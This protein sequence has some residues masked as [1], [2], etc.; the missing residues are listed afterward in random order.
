[1]TDAQVQNVPQINQQ[2]GQAQHAQQVNQ[3][4]GQAQ[5]AQHVYVYS[6]TN[7]A[8]PEFNWDG[9]LP[10]EF[11][12]FKRYCELLL[13][14]P[15]YTSRSGKEIVS[16]MLLWMGKKAVVIFD[17]MK[18]LTELQK[19]Q[20]EEVWK[21]FSAYFEPKTNFRLARFQLRD[22]KQEQT[23]PVDS[24]LTRLRT[25]AGKCHFSDEAAID[26]NILDQLIKG[27]AHTQVR[28][29]LLEQPTTLTLNRA[30]DFARTFEATQHHLQHFQQEV[31]VHESRKTQHKQQKHQHRQRSRSKSQNRKQKTK[32]S[33]YSCGTS[34]ARAKEKCPAKDQKCHKCGRIGHWAKYCLNPNNPVN[35]QNKRINAVEAD[36]DDDDITT[37][38]QNLTF[39]T[40]SVDSHT[41][42]DTRTEAFAVIKI[43]P[44]DGFVANLK[45]KV[46]TGAEVN[47]LPLRTFAQIYPDKISNGRPTNTKRST[48]ILTAYN[49][50]T[51]EQFGTITIP[52]KFQ[53]KWSNEEFYIAE[54]NGPV[55]FG[56][57]TS[58][59][60]Q[61]VKMQCQITTSKITQPRQQQ[62]QPKPINSLA[63]L[64]DSY[65]D[66]FEGL[67]RFP[68]KYHLD[69]KE[70]ATPSVHPPRKTPIQ[71]REKIEAELQ[72]MVDLDVIRQTNE[73]TD[74]VSSI[75]YVQK[76]DGSLRICLDPRD[77]NT[78]LKRGQH[79]A[80]TLEEL[81]HK[82]T[83]A[84]T[85]SKLDAKSGYW[86][87]QLDEE[88]QLLTTFNSPLG[89]YC[90]KRLPF[91]LRT[92]QDVF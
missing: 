55:I 30:L 19:Q 34:H 21:A 84:T 72:R 7:I 3:Q 76:P 39:Q 38:F 90:F 75:T 28:K 61:L 87:I 4:Q 73:P 63:D 18:E 78:A 64:R 82:L 5:H 70:N 62:T 17:N 50:N 60:L 56:L 88:S 83:G 49:G 14:T 29:K 66:R 89:R 35:K 11:K 92:S 9:E 25:Q 36:E 46:D 37:P 22:M 53:G 65:P 1:M 80:P 6:D 42:S 52:C 91:G 31:S 41:M 57:P 86:A 47:I 69:L 32:S 48:A 33:C 68:K 54:V 13:T 16:L 40:I 27:T 79:R 26:D 24:F 74:W 2:Q 71:L 51:I 15:S 10:Q 44:Y 58:N 45:G 67:G 81:S 12:T 77:I 20:P 59:T 85:F 43:K 8:P 23:E